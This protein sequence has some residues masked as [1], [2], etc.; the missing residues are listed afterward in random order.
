MTGASESDE[1][2][3]QKLK[4]ASTGK[5]AKKSKKTSVD[6]SK[7]QTNVP[8]NTSDDEE[9]TPKV[10][11]GKSSFKVV[12]KIKKA[13]KLQINESIDTSIN[14]EETPKTVKKK[15]S[16]RIDM[17]INEEETPK[18]VKKKSSLRIAQKMKSGTLESTYTAPEVQEPAPGNSRTRSGSM[19]LKRK[20]NSGEET[21]VEKVVAN[22]PISKKQR[23]DETLRSHQSDPS[24]YEDAVGKSNGSLLSN[25]LVATNKRI[26]NA[27]VV[28]ERM[29][30]TNQMSDTFVVQKPIARSSSLRKYDAKKSD[31]RMST[32]SLITDDESSPE[33]VSPK[34]LSVKKVLTK[35]KATPM[36]RW[37]RSSLATSEE[38]D[39]VPATPKQTVLKDKA[40]IFKTP[41]FSPYSKESVKKRVMAFEQVQ[42]DQDG[43]TT[44]VTRT[45]TRAMAAAEAADPRKSISA[46][47]AAARK[48]L[49]KAKKIS[50][51]R[52]AREETKEVYG[53]VQV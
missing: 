29:P 50:S 39:E 28:L 7:A 31:E 25:S 16:S 14:E 13:S 12:K 41:L 24:L 46:G 32:E 5:V 40:N 26:L 11:K 18:T 3:P 52:D 21:L 22:T 23:I 36:K 1:E 30:L 47:Q 4:K 35:V 53:S 17:P 10:V 33:R 42:Q 6:S 9:Q 38:E 20:R 27:T 34:I 49:A 51:A 44:R 48:S 43:Q 2:V 37:T 8:V 45:K 19:A 15:P